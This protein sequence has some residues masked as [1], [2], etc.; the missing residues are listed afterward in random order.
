MKKLAL[1]AVCALP[2]IAFATPEA[3]RTLFPLEAPITADG[4]GLC[5]L[6]LPAEVV[7]ACRPDLYPPG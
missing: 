7:R 2:A 4:T 6:E 3:L 5:R 1:L